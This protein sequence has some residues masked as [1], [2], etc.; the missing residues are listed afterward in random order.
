MKVLNE[1]E[2]EMEVLIEN[3]DEIKVL[4]EKILVNLPE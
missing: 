1:N 3:K 2:N 4:N